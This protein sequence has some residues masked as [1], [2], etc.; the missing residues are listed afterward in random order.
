[1]DCC[2][3]A[4]H[5]VLDLDEVLVDVELRQLL[6]MVHLQQDRRLLRVPEHLLPGQNLSHPK[7]QLG[8]P[9]PPF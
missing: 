6:P 8:L 5:R 9:Q 4:D 1:M 7:F 3:D 2:Q